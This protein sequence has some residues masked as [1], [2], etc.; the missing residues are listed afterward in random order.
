MNRLAILNLVRPP[1]RVRWKSSA[2]YLPPAGRDVGAAYGAVLLLVPGKRRETP[3]PSHAPI[4]LREGH[5]LKE[6][7]FNVLT[8]FQLPS[9][10]GSTEDG[11]HVLLPN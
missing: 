10:P 9:E 11:R 5:V 2:G 1:L 8:G 3:D 7:E 4:F 6:D